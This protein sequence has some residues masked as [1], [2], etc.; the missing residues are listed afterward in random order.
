MKMKTNSAFNT[1]KALKRSEMKSII[2]GK[3][4]ITCSGLVNHENYVSGK[5]SGSSIS[6]CKASAEKQGWDLVTCTEIDFNIA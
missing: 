2:A 1:G 6:E 3:K 4:E 5:C